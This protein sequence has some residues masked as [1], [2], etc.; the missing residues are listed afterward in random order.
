MKVYEKNGKRY[1]VLCRCENGF[2]RS[3]LECYVNDGKYDAQC[4]KCNYWF[5]YDLTNPLPESRTMKWARSLK[6]WQLV[7]L[8]FNLQ[9]FMDLNPAGKCTIRKDGSFVMFRVD[10]TD[11]ICYTAIEVTRMTVF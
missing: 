10:G 3:P 6:R 4:D 11:R 9:R 2:F 7:Q 1:R 5:S 8:R